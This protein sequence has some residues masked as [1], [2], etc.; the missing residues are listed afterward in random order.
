MNSQIILRPAVPE[1]GEAL[2]AIYAP[3][4]EKT[5]ITFEY[6]VPSVQEFRSRIRHT[7][8]KYPYIVAQRGEDIL[9]YAYTGVFKGRAAYDWAV[10]TTIY[11][12]PAQ[13]RTGLGRRLYQ[14]LEDISKAQGIC[15]LYACIGYPEIE[16]EHL[17][18]NSVRFHDHL[19][20]TLAGRFR[21]C[22]YKFGTWYD[23]VWMEKLLCTHPDRPGPIIPFPELPPEALRELGVQI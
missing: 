15:N 4:V 1:D 14:A 23:M 10:E 3:Y 11:L 2:L 21:K 13:R 18:Q 17:T 8:E 16:D 6:E 19:G 12:A 9:G 22:G 20:Y 7:L 5:A